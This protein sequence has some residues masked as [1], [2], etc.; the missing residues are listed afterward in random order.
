M[1]LLDFDAPRGWCS[2][3][4]RRELI[5]FFGDNAADL[6]EF[7]LNGTLAAL[8]KCRYWSFHNLGD[9]TAFK[10]GPN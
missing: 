4:L 5:R 6:A 10:K 1:E 3:E 9:V 2:P 8:F 7:D